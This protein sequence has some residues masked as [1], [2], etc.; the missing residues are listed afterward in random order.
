MHATRACSSVSE[1]SYVDGS[2]FSAARSSD[3]DRDRCATSRL[4]TAASVSLA[5]AKGAAAG[6]ADDVAP[7]AADVASGAADVAGSPA[8]CPPKAAFLFKR[9]R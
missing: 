1:R 2:P 8:R 6:G 9:L 4:A 5:A 3:V 7:G